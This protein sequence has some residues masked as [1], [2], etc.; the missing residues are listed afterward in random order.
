MFGDIVTSLVSLAI[1]DI[2]TSLVSLA[3]GDIVTS[4][5]SLAFGEY[6]DFIGVLGVWWGRGV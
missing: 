5:V 3:F 4:L 1:G 2:V 6:S